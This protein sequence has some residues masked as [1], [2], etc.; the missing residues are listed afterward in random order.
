[1]CVCDIARE[2]TERGISRR[3]SVRAHS[4][5]I[6]VQHARSLGLGGFMWWEASEDK[7]SLLLVAADQA[8]AAPS[9]Q[10]NTLF[11]STSATRQH[12]QLSSPPLPAMRSHSQPTMLSLAS[13][14]ANTTGPIR[15]SKRRPTQRISVS[16]VQNSTTTTGVVAVAICFVCLL[17]GYWLGRH[18]PPATRSIPVGVPANLSSS[19]E[20]RDNVKISIDRAKLQPAAPLPPG[21][22]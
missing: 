15:Q 17:L 12:L 7:D 9:S 14:P 1:M 3:V 22:A 6:K 10:S 4:I 5:A 13:S 21:T 18:S 16:I 19:G 11:A 20:P 2:R 8:W